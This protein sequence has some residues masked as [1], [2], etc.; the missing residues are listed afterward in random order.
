MMPQD[1][2]KVD[3]SI[4]RPQARLRGESFKKQ[5]IEQLDWLSVEG[6]ASSLGCT[7]K[8]LCK[9]IAAGNL[10]AI[11]FD[12]RTLIPEILMPHGK[13]L[14]NLDAVI[15]SMSISSPW[16]QLSWMI[17]PNRRLDGKTPVEALN[18]VPDAVIT[19]AKSVGV[20]GGA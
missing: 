16:L 12:E 7:E 15:R 5:V 19:L 8:R 4:E 17:A 2:G 6:A 20:Q 10:I 11:E 13:L 1:M 18:S 9:H 14:P 3:M